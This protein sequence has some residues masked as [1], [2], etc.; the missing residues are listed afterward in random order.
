[1]AAIYAL[2]KSNYLVAGIAL[3][4]MVLTRQTAIL[5]VL[6]VLLLASIRIHREKPVSI[7]KPV[8]CL[9]LPLVAGQMSVWGYN[10]YRFGN[11]FE[12][13]YRG[14]G[15]D[16]P[17]LL[18]LYSLVLSP[19]DGLLI[20]SPVLILGITGWF[21]FI[22]GTASEKEWAWLTLGLILVFLIPHALYRDWSGGGGWGPRLLLPILP[23]LILPLGRVINQGQRRLWSQFLLSIVL[24][25]SIFIQVMGV[26]VNWVRHLQRTLN[27]ASSPV[28][29]YL[30]I[31][32]DWRASPI[33]GQ[34]RS[35]EEAVSILNQPTTREILWQMVDEA[36]KVGISEKQIVDWQSKAVDQLSFNVPD[37]WFIYWYF[38]GVPIEWLIFGMLL[39]SGLVI[40]LGWK[41]RAAIFRISSARTSKDAWRSTSR[42]NIS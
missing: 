8:A 11:P 9:L 38:L 14:V 20:F 18:G 37:F 41:L 1:L 36:K 2:Y 25:I 3:A 15:W 31:H 23:Y 10:A 33:L 12:Y 19:G 42:E 34:V 28:E 17:F 24:T 6:P 26:S 40:L 13:G 29:Y 7:F 4:V 16:T 32:Y 35:L 39:L 5:L 27:A 22:K 30:R 21:F